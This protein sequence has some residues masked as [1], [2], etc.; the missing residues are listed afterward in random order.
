MLNCVGVLNV[1]QA[2]GKITAHNRLEAALI[3]YDALVTG[4]SGHPHKHIPTA[5]SEMQHETDR[6]VYTAVFTNNN[7]G[8]SSSSSNSSTATAAMQHDSA[9]ANVKSTAARLRRGPNFNSKTQ[10]RGRTSE[11]IH[12]LQ[13]NSDDNE[14]SQVQ[15]D[16][17][18][19]SS[20]SSKRSSHTGGY[21]EQQQMNTTTQQ[22]QY[23][24]KHNM[25]TPINSRNNPSAAAAA[26]TVK[27]HRSGHYSYNVDDSTDLDVSQDSSTDHNSSDGHD[28]SKRS[29]NHRDS[30]SPFTARSNQSTD[31]ALYNFQ[32]PLYFG[33]DENDDVYSDQQQ[34][35]PSSSSSSQ[36]PEAVAD[37]AAPASQSTAITP[38]SSQEEINQNA[39]FNS[40]NSNS[41][42]PQV[43]RMHQ[44]RKSTTPTKL[45]YQK[46]LQPTQIS[47]IIQQRAIAATAVATAAAAAASSPD[48]SST[49]NYDK[50]RLST[51][52]GNANDLLFATSAPASNISTLVATNATAAYNIQYN[53]SNSNRNSVPLSPAL[54]SSNY[55]SSSNNNRGHIFPH[56]QSYSHTSTAAAAMMS[57][58]N[59]QYAANQFAVNQ[60]PE[61]PHNTSHISPA[62]I[63]R[64]ANQTL[65]VFISNT[66]KQSSSIISNKYTNSNADISISS[67]AASAYNTPS[68]SLQHG[69]INTTPRLSSVPQWQ[70]I[71]SPTITAEQLLLPV[72]THPTSPNRLS[73]LV[74]TPA[75][76]AAAAARRSLQS[77][78]ATS[79]A[80]RSMLQPLHVRRGSHLGL[81]LL[82]S[83]SQPRKK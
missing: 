9:S 80:A 34:Q 1:L 72:A 56:H 60:L 28:N 49:G 17:V 30:I 59:E 58:H 57:A 41:T 8:F 64:Q 81:D 16:A 36:S 46:L 79:P 31:S 82:L 67:T 4:E 54:Y 77:S 12:S 78:P 44:R 37:N 3:A 48:Y 63:Y 53:N 20:N 83:A 14:D 18:Y 27:R 40:S 24:D 75:A 42:S 73:D 50:L 29:S 71:S 15:V 74:A 52:R 10:K 61:L 35:S 43:R 51:G 7:T 65:P 66:P 33:D 38:V 22:Q 68:A 62:M 5:V 23:T 13:A 6:V 55:T 26:T 2:A 19:G 11:I 32:G 21:V 69:N 47:P 25:A 76:A 45:N 70:P 39:A